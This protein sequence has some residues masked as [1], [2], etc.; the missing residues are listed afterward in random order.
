M[1]TKLL[2]RFLDFAFSSKKLV[3][4]GNGWQYSDLAPIAWEV[5]RV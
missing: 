3:L 4:T 1:I 5:W 2:K